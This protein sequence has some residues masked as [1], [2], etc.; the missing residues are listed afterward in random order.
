MKGNVLHGISTQ[1]L[2]YSLLCN[3]N[4]GTCIQ[5]RLKDLRWRALQQ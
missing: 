4:R 3:L 5:N 1:I 2:K